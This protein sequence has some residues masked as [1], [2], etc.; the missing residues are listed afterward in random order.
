LIVLLQFFHQNGF[1][2]L[3]SDFIEAS[4]CFDS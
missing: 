2:I 3:P 1:D 4:H